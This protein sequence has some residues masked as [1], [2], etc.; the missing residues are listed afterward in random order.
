MDT[1]KEKI[2][3]HTEGTPNPNALKFVLDKILIESGS[4][5]F[6][7]KEKSKNSP[8]A[9]KL[10][11]I[12]EVKEVFIGRDFITIS[13]AEN[14]SWDNIYEK[15]IHVINNHFDSG[16]PLTLKKEED[17]K[18]SKTSM[19]DVEQ[20]IHEILDSQ[21]RPAVASDGG[22]IIFDS[23]KDGVLRLHLQGS[24]SHCPSSIMTLKAGIESM[25]KRQIPELKEVI[26]V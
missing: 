15:L 16:E 17:T 14:A 21:I 3:I 2:K 10:F 22:D 24:C 1:S 23:Y 9:S 19:S 26:S 13:K 25:L 6:P 12:E 7:N 4:L 20:K 18:E 8:L 5:N 11:E